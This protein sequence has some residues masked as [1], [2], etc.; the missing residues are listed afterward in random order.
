M[1][2]AVRAA[3]AARDPAEPWDRDSIGARVR[4]AVRQLV[5]QR[6]QRKP[7]VLPIILEV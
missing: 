3:L 5:N 6:V 4:T 1:K 2:S 7:V